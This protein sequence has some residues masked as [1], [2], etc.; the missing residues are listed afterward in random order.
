MHEFGCVCLVEELRVNPLSNQVS[1]AAN[2]NIW[3]DF[4]RLVVNLPF[5]SVGLWLCKQKGSKSVCDLLEWNDVGKESPPRGSRLERWV[6]ETDLLLDGR[7]QHLSQAEQSL[8][9]VQEKRPLRRTEVSC[10]AR[11]GM[12]TD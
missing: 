6:P 5:S 9:E 10:L 2:N 4:V 8:P 7:A 11:S 12:T 3:G 1:A